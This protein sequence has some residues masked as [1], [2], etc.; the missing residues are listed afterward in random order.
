MIQLLNCFGILT[1]INLISS[2]S[3]WAHRF[4]CGLIKF[5][6]QGPTWPLEKFMK[7]HPWIP[8]VLGYGLTSYFGEL[9]I[10]ITILTTKV[11]TLEEWVSCSIALPHKR[12]QIR[13]NNCCCHNKVENSLL[14]FSISWCS[15]MCIF[16]KVIPVNMHKI[17]WGSKLWCESRCDLYA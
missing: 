3:L 17:F 12:K 7:L 4:S 16:T 10:P 8:R 13:P 2:C 15:F 9:K 6:L 5:L 11:R 1:E 14:H